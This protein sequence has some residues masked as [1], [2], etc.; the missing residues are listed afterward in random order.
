MVYSNICGS[1]CDDRQQRP[2]LGDVAAFR[3]SSE[4]LLSKVNEDENIFYSLALIR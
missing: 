2:G 4:P 3:D 1:F